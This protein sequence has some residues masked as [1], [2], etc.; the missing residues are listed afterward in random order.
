MNAR[1]IL[2]LLLSFLPA[3]ASA[4]DMSEHLEPYPAA[5]DGFERMVFRLPASSQGG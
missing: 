3:I 2:S 4:G 1:L 5:E